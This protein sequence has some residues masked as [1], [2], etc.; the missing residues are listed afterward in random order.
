MPVAFELDSVK[1]EPFVAAAVEPEDVELAV[2]GGEFIELAVVL[3]AKLDGVLAVE[4]GKEEA[5]I[6]PVERRVVEADA[7]AG[8]ANR[9]T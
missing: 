9:V 4:L 2:V 6:A 3:V 1:A 8:L 7:Q 5:G